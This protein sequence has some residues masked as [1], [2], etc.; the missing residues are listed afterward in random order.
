MAQYAAFL[1]AV[2]VGGTGKL[3]MADLRGICEAVGFSNAKTYL[4]SG[5]VVFDTALDLILLQAAL[6]KKLDKQ[7]GKPVGLFLRNATDLKAIVEAN[8]FKTAEGNRL[9]VILLDHQPLASVVLSAKNRRDEEIALG[10]RC[11][12]VYYPSGMGQSK[13]K[14]P[15]VAHG[16]V[17]NMNTICAVLEM[18]GG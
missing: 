8:P 12:F 9:M 4:A 17:R 3:P 14:I 1:R 6:A 7:L 2:N 5:N 13:L 10:P 16:T 15:N 18:L 11:L